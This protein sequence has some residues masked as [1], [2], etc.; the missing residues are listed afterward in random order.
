MEIYADLLVP[1][2]WRWQNN[3]IIIHLLADGQYAE[4]ETSLAFGTFP[5]KELSQFV[6]LDSTKGENARMREF[7]HWVRSNL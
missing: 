2:V 4:S 1:E 7:R 3:Q 6:Q 5:I